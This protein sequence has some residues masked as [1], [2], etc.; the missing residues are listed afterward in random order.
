MSR[1]L[2][3]VT[4]VIREAG[5]MP[6]GPWFDEAA[7]ER[8]RIVH[9]TTALHDLNDLDES[10]VDPEIMPYLEAYRLFRRDSNCKILRVEYRVERHGLYAGHPDRLVEINGLRGVLDIKPGP[11]AWHGIQLAA[12]AD[13]EPQQPCYR[14]NLY[15]MPRTSAKYRLVPRTDRRDFHVW[16]ALLTIHYWRQENGLVR[17]NEHDEPEAWGEAD[18]AATADALRD[19][20]EHGD[21]PDCEF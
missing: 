14:W 18:H 15:L 13:A 7:M 4:R 21:R 8:G 5:L 20:G 10:S 16:N 6:T 9:E 3:S 12:Y 17:S 1:R 19:G 2:V 11:S